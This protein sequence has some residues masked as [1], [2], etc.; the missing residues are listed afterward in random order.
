MI[1]ARLRKNIRNKLTKY[2]RPIGI[3]KKK[4]IA[5]WNSPYV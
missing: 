4:N 2:F 5:E 3:G 1:Y